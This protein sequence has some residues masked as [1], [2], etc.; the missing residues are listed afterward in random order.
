M[1][2]T[3]IRGV[4][5][6]WPF[7]MALCSVRTS[8]SQDARPRLVRCVCP[9]HTFRDW[10]AVSQTHLPRLVR[11]SQTHSPRWM[12]C[13]MI[14][15]VAIYIQHQLI[16]QQSSQICGCTPTQLR[17][18][19]GSVPVQRW[20]NV[21]DVDHLCTSTGPASR[22]WAWWQETAGSLIH[23]WEIHLHKVICTKLSDNHRIS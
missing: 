21:S 9:R 8:E 22:C 1:S 5:G 3:W 16:L 18:G 17:R 10:C 13:D 4:A 6:W 19:P 20:T 14:P 23:W 7:W 12:R 11:C 15:H 2:T